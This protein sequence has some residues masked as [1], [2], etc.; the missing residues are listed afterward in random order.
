[1]SL[2]RSTHD[3]RGTHECAMPFGHK[4][5]LHVVTLILL[6]WAPAAIAGKLPDQM[7][8]ILIDDLVNEIKRDRADVDLRNNSVLL[9]QQLRGVTLLRNVVDRAAAA[10]AAAARGT[11]DPMPA[12]R[13]L[14]PIFEPARTDKTVG[15][16]ASESG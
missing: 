5:V 1:M 8:K 14:V 4:F 16:S 3:R 10:S 9:E 2:I 7:R 13:A 6:V 15:A 11:P 12:A